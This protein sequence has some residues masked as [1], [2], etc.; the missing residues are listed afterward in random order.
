MFRT[1]RKPTPDYL[2]TKGFNPRTYH[3]NLWTS[4]RTFDGFLQP[5]R[6]DS[7]VGYGVEFSV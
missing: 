1:G 5:M 3:T 6:G 2:F 7:V 4:Q